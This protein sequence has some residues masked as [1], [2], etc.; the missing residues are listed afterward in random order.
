MLNSGAATGFVLAPMEK[1]KT[2]V[3][4]R[5]IDDENKKTVPHLKRQDKNKDHLRY[6]EDILSK[7]EF[8]N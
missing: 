2:E 7:I 4:N 6:G 8:T 3:V 1:T 5:Q